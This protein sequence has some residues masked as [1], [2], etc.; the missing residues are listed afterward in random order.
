LVAILAYWHGDTGFT[1]F[2]LLLAVVGLVLAVI[3]AFKRSLTK[4]LPD[5]NYGLCIG[6][7][8]PGY[9][10]DGFTDSLADLID[11]TAG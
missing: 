5:N 2:G 7:R 10:A 8:Q 9:S 3:L 11:D 1:L 4:H 6:I